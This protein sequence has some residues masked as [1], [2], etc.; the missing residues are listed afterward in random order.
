M[1]IVQIGIVRLPTDQIRADCLQRRNSCSSNKSAQTDEPAF[2]FWTF[3]DLLFTR[4]VDSAA[5]PP[6][7]AEQLS[8][9]GA[10][11][12]LTI[13]CIGPL[14]PVTGTIPQD[15]SP[16]GDRDRLESWQTL[17]LFVPMPVNGDAGAPSFDARALSPS[18]TQIL[19]DFMET[20]AQRLP[21]TLHTDGEKI[22]TVT[23]AFVAAC[24]AASPA[25]AAT[26]GPLPRQID[27]A[28]L[29][30]RKQMSSPDFGP[31]QLVC[32]LAMSRSKAYRLFSPCGGI[33]HFINRE[34]L[35]EAHRRLSAEHEVRAIHSIG[36]EVGFADHSTFSRAFRREF[37]YSPLEARQR[38]LHG[39][40]KTTVHKFSAAREQS[41]R[42]PE[43]AGTLG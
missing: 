24:L 17:T 21:V 3:G 5:C 15:G 10:A 29:I 11:C 1:S 22:A 41:E 6:L 20:L 32:Q 25:G 34:R 4:A 19:A 13:R 33:R 37:G 8:I 9:G 31:K 7:R 26:Q 38:T 14:A 39:Y 16:D 18:L 2:F 30:V 36:A 27:R 28:R 42:I 12:S 40:A 23:R 35:Y 43:G